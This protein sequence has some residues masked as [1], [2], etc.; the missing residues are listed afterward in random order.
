[1]RWFVALLLLTGIAVAQSQQPSPGTRVIERGPQQPQTQTTQQPTTPDLRGTDKMPLIVKPLQATKTPEESAQDAKD[2][3]EKAA[4]ERHTLYLGVLTLVVLALQLFAFIYQ[5]WKLRQTVTAMSAQ[6]SDM[7][8]SITES[9]RSADAA[10]KAADANVAALEI[11]R[12][13]IRAYLTIPET[14]Q[15]TIINE[16]N[17]TFLVKII[18]INTGQSSARSVNLRWVA[19]V[20]MLSIRRRFPLQEGF[21][22]F[23]D[24]GPGT[25]IEREITF[26]KITDDMR[27][28]GWR[29]F[30]CEC[31]LHNRLYRH[32]QR[33]PNQ[34]N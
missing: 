12:S 1:M 21:S 2:R 8:K 28:A 27:G 32:I 33:K 10:T 29:W 19:D 18:V 22:D 34:R 20:E 17:G 13:Q 14:P 9:K 26:P 7:Q 23:N 3:D 6:S 16:P 25:P 15:S 4:L 11:S 30:F 24:I 31:A 5:G